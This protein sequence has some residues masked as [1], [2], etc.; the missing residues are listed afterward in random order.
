MLSRVKWSLLWHSRAHAPTHTC[1]CACISEHQRKK[2]KKRTIMCVQA[3]TL[4]RT[5]VHTPHLQS[6]GSWSDTLF[7]HTFTQSTPSFYKADRYL[8]GTLLWGAQASWRCNQTVHSLRALSH[9]LSVAI[10]WGQRNA[11]VSGQADVK[12]QDTFHVAQ[13]HLWKRIICQGSVVLAAVTRRSSFRAADA[14]AACLFLSASL[15]YVP[16]QEQA[17]QLS[18]FEFHHH[19]IISWAHTVDDVNEWN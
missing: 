19:W 5:H 16:H 2:K 11:Q 3:H 10:Q 15:H 13:T 12:H 6:L 18:L 9:C 7:T 17:V 1:P 14:A 8:G 4:M